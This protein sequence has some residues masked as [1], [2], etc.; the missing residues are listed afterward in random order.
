MRVDIILVSAKPNISNPLLENFKWI[1]SKGETNLG[2]YQSIKTTLEEPSVVPT[3]KV[4]Y[5]YYIKTLQ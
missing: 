4:I 2:L 1:N 3:N 5:S